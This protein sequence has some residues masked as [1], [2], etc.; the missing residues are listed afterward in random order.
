M[1]FHVEGVS[2]VQ[3]QPVNNAAHPDEQPHGDFFGNP[4]NARCSC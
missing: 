3:E 1:N 4:L 2:R